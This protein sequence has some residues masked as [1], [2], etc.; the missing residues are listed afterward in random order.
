MFFSSLITSFIEVMVVS[1]M[2]LFVKGEVSLPRVVLS[3]D[4]LFTLFIGVDCD[5]VLTKVTQ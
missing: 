1:L 2:W 3:Y 5:S 4:V